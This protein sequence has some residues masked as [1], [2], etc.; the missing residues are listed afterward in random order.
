MRNVDMTT[1]STLAGGPFSDTSAPGLMPLLR[2]GPAQKAWH[3]KAFRFGCGAGS[4]D[5]MSPHIISM[6]TKTFQRSIIAILDVIDASHAATA[7]DLGFALL[8]SRKLPWDDRAKSIGSRGHASFH[9]F[10]DSYPS[11]RPSDAIWAKSH[12]H[13]TARPP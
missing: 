11:A 9:A 7:F 1:Q 5:V 4:I 6:C 2:N 8:L 10:D 12:W 3:M 13:S